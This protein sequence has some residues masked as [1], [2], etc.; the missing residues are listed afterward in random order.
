MTA[1]LEPQSVKLDRLELYAYRSDRLQS[2]TYS[3]QI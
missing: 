1:N 2:F 3:P